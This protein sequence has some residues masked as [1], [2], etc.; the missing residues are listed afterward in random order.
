MAIL[1]AVAYGAH[2]LQGPNGVGA[3]AA[4]RQQIRQLEKQNADLARE[5]EQK[6]NRIRRLEQSPAVQ[7]LEIRQRLK[8]VAPD[9][10]V[11]I[12]PDERK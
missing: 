3:L 2:S 10:K 4:K 1:V 7:E 11:Y 9:E 8:V 5:I 12:L 6:R